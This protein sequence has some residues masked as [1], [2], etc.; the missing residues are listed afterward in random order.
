MQHRG[1]DCSPSRLICALLTIFLGQF[2]SFGAK[3]R[4]ILV[5]F[6]Q[7][8]IFMM[9]VLSTAY[10]SKL[11]AFMF[12]SFY[13]N[14][15]KTI[16]DLRSSSMKIVTVDYFRNFLNTTDEYPELR[17]RLVDMQMTLNEFF[18]Q[19]DTD[20]AMIISCDDFSLKYY[21]ELLG[22]E[23]FYL[24]KEKFLAYFEFFDAGIQNPFVDKLQHFMDW[25]FASG[26]VQHWNFLYRLEKK[27]RSDIGT[28]QSMNDEA[29]QYLHLK[30]MTQV[31]FLFTL[32][33]IASFLVFLGEI[34]NF[35]YAMPLRAFLGGKIKN[36]KKNCCNLWFDMILRLTG[37]KYK[38]KRIQVEPINNY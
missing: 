30:D 16:D 10:Q 6:I 33:L 9:I 29:N 15:L 1:A 20:L 38:A 36:L 35:K 8:S 14:H 31:F 13:D 2:I 23:K 19:N 11:T 34:L 27:T 18:H 3:N 24:L 25:R 17:A 4:V 5:I 7:I 22:H 12:E 32:A 37:R 28:A 21:D 26:I